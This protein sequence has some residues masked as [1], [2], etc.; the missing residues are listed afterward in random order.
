[1]TR[2]TTT[3]RDA[4][5][6]HA[7]MLIR[8]ARRTGMSLREAQGAYVMGMLEGEGTYWDGTPMGAYD[9]HDTRTHEERTRHA[10]MHN[11]AHS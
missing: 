2:Y 6:A 1:M 11:T 3:T 10:R 8:E 9:P 7:R 5:L 4:R